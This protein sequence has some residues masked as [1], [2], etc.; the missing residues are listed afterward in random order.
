MLKLLAFTLPLCLDTFAVAFAVLGEMRLTRAQRIRVWVLFIAFEAGMPLLGMALGAPLAH[1]AGSPTHVV[2]DPYQLGS[3]A[4]AYQLQMVD[5]NHLATTV[6][7]TFV[8]RYV[9]PIIVPVVVGALGILMLDECFNGDDDDDDDD[10][11]GGD[12][13]E[14]RKAKALVAARGLSVIA[15]GIGISLDELV[16]GFT[17]SFTQLPVRDVITAIVIQAFVALL[18]GQFLGRKARAGR[19]RVSTERITTGS[20][21][22][23]GSVLVTLAVVLLAGPPVV[24]R[25]LPHLLPHHKV[26]HY[27]APPAVTTSQP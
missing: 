18:V 15:L 22:A 3:P 1:L 11:D 26:A 21:L 27:V 23:A 19:L 5:R 2:I 24:T 10:D 17:I 12:D 14:V 13:D 6:D 7:V 20:K 25:V 16:V 8:G 4:E 9:L